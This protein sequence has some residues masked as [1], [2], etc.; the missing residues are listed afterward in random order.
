M[1][2]SKNDKEKNKEDKRGGKMESIVVGIV[3]AIAIGIYYLNKKLKETNS[4]IP[5]TETDEE[6]IRLENLLEEWKK[7]FIGYKITQLINE[8]NEKNISFS[9]NKEIDECLEKKGI[10][11]NYFTPTISI[12]MHLTNEI[13]E[14]IKSFLKK[15]NYIIHNIDKPEKDLQEYLLKKAEKEAEI[16]LNECINN[17]KDEK[18]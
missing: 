12:P 9:L 10:E 4:Y 13:R 1:Y 14:Q 7:K 18:I 3:I 8:F 11:K 15:E 17:T 2:Y 5:E 16:I 6:V